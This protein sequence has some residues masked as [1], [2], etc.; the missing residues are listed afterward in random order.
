LSELRTGTLVGELASR[1]QTGAM[2]KN[3]LGGDGGC[4]RDWKGAATSGFVTGRN[5]RELVIAG[6]E[7]ERNTG[8]A[9]RA[10]GGERRGDSSDGEF[11][12]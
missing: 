7:A 8:A 6:Y 2:T 12:E 5:R 1:Y 4:R 3:R 9:C 10:P 11:S